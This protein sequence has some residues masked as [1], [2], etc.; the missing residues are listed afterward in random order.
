MSQLEV[1]P[2]TTALSA[3]E[4]NGVVIVETGL[5]LWITTVV[6][7]VV[8]C[9]A[10]GFGIYVAFKY[11]A[12]NE[13]DEDVKRVITGNKVLSIIAGTFI[14]GLIVWYIVAMARRSK[15]WDNK[16]LESEAATLFAHAYGEKA[17]EL[18]V[19]SGGE[20][21]TGF[22]EAMYGH[23]MNVF[24]D[25]DGQNIANTAA[26]YRTAGT[27]RE[28]GSNAANISAVNIG[29]AINASAAAT[30]AA[31]ETAATTAAA[32]ETAAARQREEAAA[33]QRAAEESRPLL[34]GLTQRE[35]EATGGREGY[36]ELPSPISLS[37]S[38]RRRKSPVKKKKASPS[39]LKKKKSPS[40]LKKKSTSSRRK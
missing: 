33:R 24:N 1:V 20:K 6:G 22:K 5:S 10:I 7:I 37:R 16:R 14:F 34:G 2:N 36:E 23:L 17:K 19:G 31:A 8:L 27:S 9:V 4:K 11:P 32:A 18:A 38:Y 39:S 21:L 12:E 28:D 26:N 25:N 3:Y 35:Q 29:S 40:S 15:T 30:A 13:D